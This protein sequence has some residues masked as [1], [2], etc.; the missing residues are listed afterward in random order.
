MYK[1]KKD[2]YEMLFTEAGK[3]ITL[4]FSKG[5]LRRHFYVKE[6]DVFTY[7][8][9]W[10]ALDCSSL[11]YDEEP[12]DKI[13]EMCF[14]LVKVFQM[15]DLGGERIDLNY[16]ESML[17][18]ALVHHMWA[19]APWPLEESEEYVFEENRVTFMKDGEKYEYNMPTSEGLTKEELMSR[20]NEDEV[21]EDE[22][23]EDEVN[24][25]EDD[26]ASTEVIDEE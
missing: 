21:N 16:D 3:G 24:E 12:E 15:Y 26:D 7:E 17:L 22:V 23:N 18:E 20:E 11:E 1:F 25:D 4:R 2:D 6:S 14:N 19:D 9:K 10:I 8:G 13:Q 5:E